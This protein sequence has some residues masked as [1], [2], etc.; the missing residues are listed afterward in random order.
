VRV[1]SVDLVQVDG[2]DAEAAQAVLARL[3]DVL[4]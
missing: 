2:V 1:E 3:L 4:T